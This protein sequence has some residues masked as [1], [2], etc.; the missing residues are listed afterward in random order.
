MDSRA[1]NRLSLINLTLLQWLIYAVL[2][3]TGILDSPE[4]E[5]KVGWAITVICCLIL[6]INLAF[7]LCVGIQ[8][9]I[10]KLYLKKLKKRACTYRSDKERTV[11]AVN[12]ID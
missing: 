11:L 9:I 8:G 4:T 3:L 6:T 7:I 1:S 12:D 10:K 5:Y 2:L